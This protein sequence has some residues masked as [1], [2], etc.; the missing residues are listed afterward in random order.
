MRIP[1]ATSRIIF[2]DWDEAREHLP[3]VGPT[4]AAENNSGVGHQHIW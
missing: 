4:G 1:P 2:I 3:E